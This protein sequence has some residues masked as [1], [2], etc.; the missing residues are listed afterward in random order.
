MFPPLEASTNDISIV[1]S[2][3]MGNA[4]LAYNFGQQTGGRSDFVALEIYQ[5]KAR[6]MFGGSQTAIAAISVPKQVADGK[7]YRVTAT[8]NGRIGSL[9]VGE[10]SLTGESCRDC[11]SGDRTCSADYTGPTGTLNFSNQPMYLGGVATIEAIQD[12]P[13]QV[14]SDDFVGCFQSVSVNGRSLNLSSPLKS[15]GVTSTCHRRRDICNVHAPSCGTG[16]TCIDGWSNATCVCQGGLQAPN[17]FVALEPLSFTAG[18]YVEFHIS[19]RHRR[20]QILQTLYSSGQKWKREIQVENSWSNTRLSRGRREIGEAVSMHNSVSVSFRTVSKNG[21]LFFAATNNDFTTLRLQDGLLQYASRYGSGSLVNMTI[22]DKAVADG[23]WH[24][25]TLTSKF[26]ALRLYLDGVEVGDELDMSIVHD[27]MDPYLTSVL[28]GASNKDVYNMNEDMFEFEGCLANFTV[29]GEIQPLNGSGGIFDRVIHHG[30]ILAG[31]SNSIAGAST[32]PDP[33]SI[34][35]TLVIVFFVILLVAILISFVVVRVRRQ[36][37][38]K[39]AGMQINK[40]NGG[41]MM[42]GGSVN[43][44]SRTLAESGYVETSDVSEDGC[45]RPSL[46]QDLTSKKFREREVTDHRDRDRP[47]RPDIIE[48][49]VVNK[50]PGVP[51]RVEDSHLGDHSSMTGLG[52]LGDCEGPEHY[53]LENASSIA[54]SDIDIVYHYKGYRDGNVRKYKTNPHV[55][56]YHKHNHRHSPH[57]FASP[58]HRESPRNMLRS[59]PAPGLPGGPPVAPPRESPGVLKMQSTP[60]ARLSPSSELSQQTPRILTLQDLSGKPLQ[61]ALLATSQV[62][63]VKDVMSTSERSLNSPVS[64]LSQSTS[65]IRNSSQATKKKKKAG[66]DMGVALGLTAEEIE[67]LN[68]RPRNSSLVSTL[69]AV[70][71]SS[72]DRPR[73][74]EKLV[75]LMETN[76][77]LLET[78]ESSTDESGNDSFTCSEFEYENNYEKVSRD[79]GPGNMIFSKLAE[80]ENENEHDNESGKH[81]DGFD[82]FRGSLSTLVASDDDLSNISAYKP[83]NGSSLGWDYLL[84]WGPNFESLVGVFKDIAELPDCNNGRTNASSRMVVCPKASEEYI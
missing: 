9:S 57:S 16:G 31:C 6:F 77:E 47:Q 70:S 12:R 36:Q 68:S 48:R 15:R 52:G 62:G 71:S 73:S 64:Q 18:S 50:S 43:D 46:T 14:H 5:G 23:S 7:W 44:P 32:A 21:Y 75:E 66:S 82:S 51:L 19:E 1:F 80:V 83:P 72:D 38:D 28:I 53:D 17:C 54:P 79:F 10:C 55:P 3:N 74:K 27:F 26:R 34:G 24:N 42:G 41:A 22:E 63:G 35:I 61:T 33:L 40:H 30:R 20:R 56:S 2:T 59:S 67:R 13:G 8:R 58:P 25:V 81:Y 69:D 39:K 49:E 78:A 65:S 11:R 29:N 60:L 4:L 37:R 76:T 45:V 84:N